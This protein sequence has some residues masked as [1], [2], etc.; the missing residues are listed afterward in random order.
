MLLMQR[1]PT[2][3]SLDDHGFI[4]TWLSHQPQ[5]MKYIDENGEVQTLIA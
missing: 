4:P 1:L 5:F 2:T 3:S